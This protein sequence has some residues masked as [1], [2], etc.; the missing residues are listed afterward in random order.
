MQVGKNSVKDMF[1]GRG[2]EQIIV[3]ELQRDYV[4]GDDNV[5]ALL[6]GI[7]DGFKKS[8]QVKCQATLEHEST[9]KP[10][11]GDVTEEFLAFYRRNMLATNIGF[12]YAYCDEEFAGKYFLIDGQQ[13]LTT[14]FILLLAIA[15]Q[16]KKGDTEVGFTQR[17][18]PGDRLKLDYKVREASHDFMQEFVKY[19]LDGG[20]A[21]AVRE[22]AWYFREYK[23][24]QT[25]ESTIK[26]YATITE[27]FNR[28]DGD[29]Q[30]F[31]SYI[32]DCV[33]FWYFDTNLS[34]QGE[35]LYISLNSRGESTQS[36]ENL[37]A[38]LLKDQDKKDDWGK[39]WE[40]WQDFFWKNRG[41]NPNA[42]VGF[43]QFL[44]CA[45]VIELILQNGL[46]SNTH[47]EDTHPED[48]HLEAA[49][50]MKLEDFYG[51]GKKISCVN[52]L[53]WQPPS[54]EQIKEYFEALGV[55]KKHL[56]GTAPDDHSPAFKENPVKPWLGAGQ[57]TNEKKMQLFPLLAY[58]KTCRGKTGYDAQLENDK[59]CRSRIVGVARFFY[60]IA[61][62]KGS[63]A[64]IRDGV[65]LAFA[66]ANVESND[67]C[68]PDIVSVITE[69]S[70]PTLAEQFK[71]IV[72]PEEQAKI[73]LYK[74][75]PVGVARSE[76]EKMFWAAEDH[77][78]NGGC[79]QHLLDIGQ[80]GWNV[81]EP[82][83]DKFNLEVFGK[84]NSAFN[85]LFSENGKAKDMKMASVLFC[86][87]MIGSKVPPGYYSS[88]NCADWRKSVHIEEFATFLKE[89]EPK[90][91]DDNALIN[92]FREKQRDFL[93][94]QCIEK[95]WDL[96]KDC[97]RLFV[98][99]TLADRLG[100]NMWEKGD[101]VAVEK[102]SPTDAGWRWNRVQRRYYRLKSDFRGPYDNLSALIKE[103]LTFSNGDDPSCIQQAAEKVLN[104]IRQEGAHSDGP[105]AGR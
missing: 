49:D 52:G 62:S 30:K 37:K 105:A 78:V 16:A 9:V 22:Q 92:F 5:T 82:S 19:L 98:Y 97:D 71:G 21:G 33:Q 54:L 75:P 63:P 70:K 51:G 90:S 41:D 79:I 94:N 3:P 40:E 20:D 77:P 64:N 100:I 76:L 58:V 69:K 31:G 15:A 34:E 8:Q 17:Y 4:W 2:I 55:I 29:L 101:R 103:K 44:Q 99:A 83:P 86:Y 36:H 72:T 45:A 14:I 35:Q 26:A 6:E 91:R 28:H 32:E 104:D 67:A 85:S 84:F 95:I 48:T 7:W 50:K 80:D 89:F 10:V 87:G 60:N 42:D 61:R 56:D 27:W 57:I 47:P 38:M 102:E 96:E 24:D 73:N 13:R 18:F 66:L 81:S 65:K 43:G 53:Q 1:D 59:E 88:F 25:I 74:A 46:I 12:I 68:Y 23:Y 11:P 93:K 39:T